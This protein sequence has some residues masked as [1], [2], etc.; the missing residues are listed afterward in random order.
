MTR[1]LTAPPPTCA[2]GSPADLLP[3]LY[4]PAQSYGWSAGMRA[5]TRALLARLDLPRGPLL[6]IGCGGAQLLTDLATDYP[7]HRVYGVDVHP[8]ALARAQARLNGHA[9]LIR[10]PLQRLPWPDATFALVLALDVFDQTGVDLTAALAESYR[11]LAPGG[12]LLLRLSAHP[13]LYGP[14]DVAFHTGR[15]YARRQIVT[16]LHGAG[17]TVTRA[18][19]ANITLGGPVAALRL[20]QRA[21]LAPWSPAPYRNRLANV[22]AA[23]LLRREAAW[24]RHADLPVGLSLCVIAEK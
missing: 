14:H 5:V 1:P 2:A 18:T 17:F 20:L 21:R 22:V 24:L 12:S 15:R 13:R 16:A 6:E 19:Y 7:L 3:L 8:L 11:L 9:A 23:W 10:A 4:D